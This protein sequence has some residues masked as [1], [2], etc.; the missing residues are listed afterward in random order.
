MRNLLSMS[1][2][3]TLMRIGDCLAVLCA[4]IVIYLIKFSLL[5]GYHPQLELYAIAL[6]V[7]ALPEVF[8]LFGVYEERSLQDVEVYS[9]RLVTAWAF[10]VL[11][12]LALGFLTQTI[13]AASR[14]WVSLWFVCG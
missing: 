1:E 3:T 12:V 11:L 9:G 7:L 5:A 13:H 14:I 2:I 10:V 8:R 6:G 4:G